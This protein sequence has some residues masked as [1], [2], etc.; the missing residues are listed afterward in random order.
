MP[1]YEYEC[2]ACDFHFERRQKFHE[3][4]IATCPECQGQVRRVLH[5]VPVIF[6]GSGF[7]TTDSRKGLATEP[8]KGKRG[9]PGKKKGKEKEGESTPATSH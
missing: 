6:K 2:D 9:T 3:P 4:P 8:V 7:Y 1:T 5:P